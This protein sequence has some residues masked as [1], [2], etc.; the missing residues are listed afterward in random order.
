MIVIDHSDEVSVQTLA[1]ISGRAEQFVADH[2]SVNGRV[3][4]FTISKDSE[5][6]LRPIFSKCR[7]Q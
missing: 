1:E 6:S 5:T 7:P 4:V 3:S 2:V